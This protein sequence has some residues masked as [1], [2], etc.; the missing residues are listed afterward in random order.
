MSSMEPI[1]YSCNKRGHF[2]KVCKTTFEEH[3]DEFEASKEK[4]NNE[5]M[6]FGEIAGLVYGMSQISKQ[7]QSMSKLTVPH[8]LYDELKW[9]NSQPPAPPYIKL[10]VRVDTKAFL[11]NNFKPPSAYRHR[12]SEMSV[13]ADTGCQACCMGPDELRKLGLSKKDLLP[14]DMKLNGANGS[15]IQ[16]LGAIFVIISGH[17]EAGKQDLIMR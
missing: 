11:D 12:M 16:I 8:M 4:D 1:S 7:V 2:Q 15:K 9:I 17:D 13:L 14:V 3:V 10:Q 6:S 5:Q